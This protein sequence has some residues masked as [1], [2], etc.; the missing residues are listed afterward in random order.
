MPL[1]CEPEER[2]DLGAYPTRFLLCSGM[3]LY[4]VELKLSNSVC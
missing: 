2:R 1:R 3:E 4:W